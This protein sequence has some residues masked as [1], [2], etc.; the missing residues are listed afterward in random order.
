MNQ[1]NAPDGHAS[2]Q[3]DRPPQKVAKV[4]KRHSLDGDDD[5][6]DD[7]EITPMIDM[8]F[9]LLI[10][11]MVATAVSVA[12]TLELPKADTGRAEQT[13]GRVVLVLDYPDGQRPGD[14]EPLSGSQFVKLSD[15]R[16]Y[17]LNRPKNDIA[18]SQLEAALRSEF[19]DKPRAQFVLQSSR[20]MPF[21]VV[22]E[23][24][25]SANQAGARETLVG[26]SMR[27]LGGE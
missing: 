26:V 19:A 11:F 13:E 2:S 15:V 21:A 16:L 8:T 25:K 12:S 27:R 23:V 20:K 10:F 1:I 4:P 17:L 7:L 3:F 18:P 24:L 6:D 22:R 14:D 9:L 5:D